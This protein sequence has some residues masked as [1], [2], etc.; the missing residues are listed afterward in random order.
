MAAYKI[1]KHINIISYGMLSL[2]IITFP[3]WYVQALRSN[4]NKMKHQILIGLFQKKIHIPTTDGILEI[5]AGRGVK[6]SG[7]PGRRW[8]W[9]WKSLLQ[10]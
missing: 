5:L 10:G 7:N 6:D 1:Q 2:H 8:S 4:V 3:Q 9:T